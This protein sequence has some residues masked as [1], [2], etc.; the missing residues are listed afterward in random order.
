MARASKNETAAQRRGRLNRSRGNS[1]ERWVCHKLGIKR[2]GMFGN[3]IDG[4]D[5]DDWI[6]VQVKSGQAF[7]TRIQKLLDSIQA[8]GGQLR[9]VVHVTAAGSGVAK[10]ALITMS[11][12]EFLEW[13]GSSQSESFLDPV[14]SMT[15]TLG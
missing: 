10:Q 5:R 15:E 2:V 3:K 4:G 13:H 9:A 14:D 12:E 7:P 1:I 6:V 8:S 11:L